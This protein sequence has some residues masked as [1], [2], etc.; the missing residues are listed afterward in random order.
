LRVS[1]LGDDVAWMT[2]SRWI[3]GGRNASGSK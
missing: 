1:V 2:D 3:S